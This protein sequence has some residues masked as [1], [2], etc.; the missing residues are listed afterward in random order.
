MDGLL[1]LS[2]AI[3]GVN[4]FLGRVAAVLV[5][6]A[7]LISATNAFVR[8]A[9]DRSSNAWLEIQW[10]LFGA[11]VLLGAAETLRRNEHVR[12]DLIYS[13]RSEPTRLRLD[14]GGILVFLLPFALT[15]A[16]LS[17]PVAWQ[18][19]VT[20]EGSTSAGGLIRWP[21]KML[22]P[23]GFVLL[24]LQG[25][26]ELIKRVAALRGAIALDTSYSKPEQ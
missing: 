6:L 15:M 18:S 5:L 23:V 22:L 1:R 17:W 11:I 7:A 21:F 3:D 26:S 24:A 25:L 10:Y 13:G 2:R 9:F 8:Y 16:Y 4:A 14:I 19:F 12:V 20:Q